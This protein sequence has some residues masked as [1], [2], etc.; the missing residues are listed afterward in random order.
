MVELRSRFG[1]QIKKPNFYEP[2]ETV[3][4]DDYLEEEHDSDID[5]NIDTEDE[6][7]SGDESEYDDDDDEEEDDNGNLKDFIV[8]DEDEEEDED[9]ESEEE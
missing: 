5:S 2:E 7:Q 6:Y 8:D 9:Y 3:L 1:R 4:E